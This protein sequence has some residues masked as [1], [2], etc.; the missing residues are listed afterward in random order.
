MALSQP[1]VAS[2]RSSAHIN[3]DSENMRISNPLRLN[4][5][6]MTK[7]LCV[8]L[9]VQAVTLLVLRIGSDGAELLLLRQAICFVYLTF[10]PGIVL[11]RVLKLHKLGSIETLVYS[12][13]LSLT[14][15][16]I[17]GAILN[18][19]L[20]LAGIAQ[21]ISLTPLIISLTAIVLA[22]SIVGY[23]RDRDYSGD[24]SVEVPMS[25][26][27]PAILLLIIPFMA[28]FGTY[29]INRSD[30]NLML[31]ALIFVLGI[32]VLLIGLTRIIPKE[33][34]PLVI[35]VIA[36]SLLFHN[37]LISSSLI[38]WDIHQEK[39]LADQV[40]ASGSWSTIL[41][42]NINSMLSIMILAPVYSIFLNTDVI[43]VYKVV[44]PLLFAI[45]PVALYQAYRKQSNDKIA[46]FSIFVFTSLVV[47][48]TE[49]LQ[50]ARQE[51]AELFVGLI[52]LL[53]IDRSMEKKK[54]MALFVLF[55]FS[56]VLSHYG[57]TLLFLGMLVL[58]WG[59]LYVVSLLK[60]E[61]VQDL[62]RKLTPALILGLVVFCAIW[63]I[64]TS[65]GDPFTTIVN[66]TYKISDPVV[67]MASGLL[68]HQAA[69]LPANMTNASAVGQAIVTPAPPI[70]T[71]PVEMI[72]TGGQSSSMHTNYLYLL[73]VTQGLLVIGML[74]VSLVKGPMK[75]SREFYALSFV[76]LGILAVALVL[77]KF[78]ASLNMTR[79]YQI[80]L[81]VLAPFVVLGWI[82]LFQLPGRLAKRDF[83]PI[84]LKTFAVLMVVYL[85]FNTGLIFEV[86][87]DVPMSYSLNKKGANISYTI[88]NNMEVKGA[89]WLIHSRDTTIKANNLSYVPPIVS[90]TNNRLLLQDWNASRA[91]S[92]PGNVNTIPLGSYIFM[93]TFNVMTDRGVE[94]IWAGELQKP[95][96]IILTNIKENRNR[97]YAS[98]GSAVYL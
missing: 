29:I 16:M 92:L 60:K 76:N 93:G 2:T 17:T 57:L 97:I 45:L 27:P 13:G 34:Y 22:L 10:I 26:L 35:F 88:Y 80:T 69:P 9:A 3:P 59:L 48:F 37:S 83:L 25:A 51:I 44:F 23:I 95:V 87:K 18:T 68:I 4:D 70:T 30:N 90:D 41:E 31:V 5:W 20:P 12:V 84:A 96:S 77:P 85:M 49:M 11:L 86:F 62:N 42:H 73:L 36:L 21:P 39:Y 54:W 33:L 47:T 81:L 6:N 50:L 28:I 56:L 64:N 65:S 91:Y 40:I 63:Y 1:Y 98:G 15:V 46:F 19:F 53:L 89:D 61:S 94:V 55:T 79:L 58:A 82:S 38:G 24:A 72:T 78:A 67:M 8:I 32:I 74:A 7:F 43:W 14:T 71:Q 75:L 66:T 52:I